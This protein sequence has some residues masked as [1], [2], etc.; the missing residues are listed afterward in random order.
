[1]KTITKISAVLL[2]F[3][4]L[5]VLCACGAADE[6]KGTWT[7]TDPDYGTVTWVFDGK[8]GCKMSNDLM[9]ETEG[10]YTIDGGNVSIKLELWDTPVVYAFTVDGSSLSLKDTAG[11][12]ADYDLTKQ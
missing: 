12:A 3:T 1:M 10:A 11:M 5:F 2:V 6:L 8:G 9:D 7:G 4:M